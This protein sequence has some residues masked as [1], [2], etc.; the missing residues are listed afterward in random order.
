FRLQQYGMHLRVACC[1]LLYRKALRLSRTALGQTTVGQMVNLLS[2][3][4]NKFDYTLLHIPFLLIAPLVTLIITIVLWFYIRPTVLVG[5]A[6][7]CAYIPVQ[8]WISRRFQSLR[9]E[10]AKK[11][12]ERCRLMNEIIPA[13]RVIKMYVW[14]KPFGILVNDARREEVAVIQRRL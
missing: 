7:V 5:V 4:V 13:M 14:E 11:T 3:D 1:N 2:N 6:M 12:D 10:T 9:T 8:T